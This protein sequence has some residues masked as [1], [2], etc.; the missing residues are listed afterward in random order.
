MKLHSFA[1]CFGRGRFLPQRNIKQ[2]NG[3]WA[4]N[5]SAAKDINPDHFAG[6][7]A[8][9]K[10]NERNEFHSTTSKDRKQPV[11]SES[12]DNVKKTIYLTDL[13]KL[14]KMWKCQ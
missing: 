5:V 13:S 9:H 14:E 1:L 8:P 7:S 4:D 12:L 10:I 3:L 6:S 11:C 2:A